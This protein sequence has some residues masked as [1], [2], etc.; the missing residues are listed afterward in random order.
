MKMKCVQSLNQCKSLPVRQ[1][2]V[3]QTI[4]IMKAHGGELAIGASE[5]GAILIITLPI[6]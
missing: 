5:S 6:T 1:A 4:Y 3:M 2:G